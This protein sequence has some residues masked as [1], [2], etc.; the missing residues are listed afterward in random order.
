MPYFLLKKRAM[1]VNINDVRA[2]VNIAKAIIID[3]V[4]Y[5]VI[6]ITPNLCRLGKPSVL[7]PVLYI[8]YTLN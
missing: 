6:P 8:N 2:I 4:S 5:I 3:S 1:I 7:L